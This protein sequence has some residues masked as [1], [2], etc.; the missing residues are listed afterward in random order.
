ME[1]ELKNTEKRPDTTD[2][3]ALLQAYSTFA[4]KHPEDTITPLYLYRAVSLSMGMGKGET[5][6]QFIDKSINEYPQ[7]QYLAQNVFLKAYVYEN[8]LSNLGQASF[9][10]REFLK[11]F[12]QH[13]LADDAQAAIDNLGK[14]PEEMIKEFESK[15][16]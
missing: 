8:L 16:Q 15:N 5:A 14:T 9:F 2:L 11:L 6:I 4:E 7:S 1:E 10:Y 3:N 12:P 13:E